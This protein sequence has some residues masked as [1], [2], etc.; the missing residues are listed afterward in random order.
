MTIKGKVHHVGEVNQVSDKFKKQELVIL[1]DSSQYPQHIVMEAQQDK[2]SVLEGLK[3]G[4]TVECH[5]N[6]RGREWTNPQGEVRYFNTIV[7]WKVDKSTDSAP[8]N[9][10]PWE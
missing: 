10:L 1:D 6:L 3:I 8:T 5:I 7:V 4:E 2:I 9:D